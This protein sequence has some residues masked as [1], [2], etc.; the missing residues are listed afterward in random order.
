MMDKCKLDNVLDFY[1]MGNK[2]KTMII[3]LHPLE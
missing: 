3:E 1:I 2:L